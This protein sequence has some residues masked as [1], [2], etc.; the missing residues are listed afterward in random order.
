MWGAPHKIDQMDMSNNGYIVSTNYGVYPFN[1]NLVI[2]VNLQFIC[3]C[4]LQ[5]KITPQGTLFRTN[6]P[7]M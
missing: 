4:T 2:L 7:T 5:C 3:G 6:Y 1:W